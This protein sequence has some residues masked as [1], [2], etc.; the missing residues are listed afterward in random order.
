MF[1]QKASL[2][3]FVLHFP[4]YVHAFE[5]QYEQPVVLQN[6]AALRLV[7]QEQEAVCPQSKMP[8][9]CARQFQLA[10]EAF[11]IAEAVLRISIIGKPG[12]EVDALVVHARRLHEQGWFL[13]ISA[14]TEYAP[15]A[16][17]PETLAEG[18]GQ[19]Q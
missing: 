1:F 9:V 8:S 11:R 10:L 2:T 5:V 17:A 12:E 7:E 18:E 13:Y 14:L 3:V 6:F 16:P 15:S 19:G 4:L